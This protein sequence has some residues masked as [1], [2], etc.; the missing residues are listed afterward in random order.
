MLLLT[1]ISHHGIFWFNFISDPENGCNEGQGRR[2]HFTVDNIA[3]NIVGIRHSGEPSHRLGQWSLWTSNL[4]ILMFRP[5]W[6]RHNSPRTSRAVRSNTKIFSL[7]PLRL[8]LPTFLPFKKVQVLIFA[9]NFGFYIY[10]RDVEGLN[11]KNE[12][13]WGRNGANRT[14]ALTFFFGFSRSKKRIG[15]IRGKN[16]KLIQI[17]IKNWVSVYDWLCVLFLELLFV[18][19]V[20]GSF[21]FTDNCVRT[22]C[23][24]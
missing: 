4:H 10:E 6:T 13:L 17:L 3:I 1:K 21:Y 8:S 24:K 16:K 7:P 11:N 18:V 9:S 2:N 14:R 5:T 19:P 23:G 22:Q 20:D 12:I 15:G